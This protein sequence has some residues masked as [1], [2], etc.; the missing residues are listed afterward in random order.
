MGTISFKFSFGG[1][2]FADV[3]SNGITWEVAEKNDLGIDLALFNDK[4]TATID[5]FDEKRTGI[6]MVR[7]YL[8]QIVGLNGHNPAANVGAVSSKV[9]TSIIAKIKINKITIIPIVSYT[10]GQILITFVN[11]SLQ[12]FS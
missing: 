1:L 6:Y 4:F 11:T 12:I 3:A 2:G 9:F 10:S 7:N 8:P 5:Y